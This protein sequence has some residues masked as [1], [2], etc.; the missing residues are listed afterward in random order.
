MHFEVLFSN[1][2]CSV[3]FAAFHVKNVLSSVFPESCL[4]IVIGIL[5]GLMLFVTGQTDYH[6]DARTFFLILL[7][8]IILDAGYFMPTRAFFENIGTILL[9]AVVGT[10]AVRVNSRR[11]RDGISRTTRRD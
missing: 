6:L 8:P 2:V 10:P 11:D 4:L 7:P 1:L 5:L 9:F 3:C